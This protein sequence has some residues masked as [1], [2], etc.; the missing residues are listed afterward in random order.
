MAQDDHL[1]FI[2][3]NIRKKII[4]LHQIFV[5]GGEGGIIEIAFY[6][7]VYWYFNYTP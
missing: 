5:G 7:A 6:D 2:L 1:P 3:A 4:F